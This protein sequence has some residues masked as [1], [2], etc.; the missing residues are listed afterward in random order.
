MKIHVNSLEKIMGYGLSKEKNIFRLSF[1][2]YRLSFIVYR[3]SFIVYR[4][5]FIV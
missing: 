5:S 1:I 2:V 3:L 4:L